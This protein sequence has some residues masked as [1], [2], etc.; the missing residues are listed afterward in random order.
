M[1]KL[2]TKGTEFKWNDR[3]EERF[4]KVKEFGFDTCLTLLKVVGTYTMF[5]TLQEK[6]T[7][8]Y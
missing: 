3:C 8:L 7:K 6:G 2:L 4:R 1:T 5:M